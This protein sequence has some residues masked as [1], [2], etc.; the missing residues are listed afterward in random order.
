[1]PVYSDA[2]CTIFFGNKELS[3]DPATVRGTTYSQV[4]QQQPFATYQQ[5]LGF[6]DLVLLHQT[7]G[8]DGLYVPHDSKELTLFTYDG[9]YVITTT[10]RFGIGVATADCLPVVMTVFDKKIGAVIHAGW[11]GLLGGI[12][13]VVLERL[14]HEFKVDLAD[15]HVFVGPAAGGCCYEVGQDFIATNADKRGFQQAVYKDGVTYNFDSKV[16]L[17]NLLLENRIRES[18]I[19]SSYAVCT[20]CEPLYCSYRREKKSPLRQLTILSLK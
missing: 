9:D 12:V 8:I 18:A 13:Q 4:A 11:R 3:V 2:K 15:I 5:V 7:H 10:S 20:I 14:Q 6:Q 1:M 19:N 17:I 16:F